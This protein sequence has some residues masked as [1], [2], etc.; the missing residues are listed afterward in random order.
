MKPILLVVESN[1]F[2][3]KAVELL[4]GE[5][6]VRLTDLQRDQLLE[7]VT[8]VDVLWVRLRNMIDAEVIDRANN[9]KMIATNTTGLNHI[10]LDVAH[11][12]NISVVS[13]KGEYDFLADIRATAEHTIGLT[14]ALLRRIP[15]AHQHVCNGHWDRYPFKGHELYQ[16]TAGIIGLGRL[17]KITARYFK[18]F[19][20]R[21]VAT[22][23]NPDQSIDEVE[24]VSLD[25]L[26]RESDVIS[27]HVDYKPAN[28]KMIDRNLLNKLRPNAVFINTSRG[29][30]VDESDLLDALKSGSIAGAALDV[31]DSEHHQ[32][33]SRDQLFQY[34]ATNDNLI[35]TPHIGG[36]TFESHHKTEEYLA[37]LVVKQS[38]LLN[39]SRFN[40]SL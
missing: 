28:R 20:M 30:L 21:I 10:D 40:E 32:T 35:M 39:S 1:D 25:E 34:A 37:G 14:L 36:N 18:A 2:S 23:P 38:R 33:S 31:I 9:L 29:E 13:L 5:F 22:D 24:F 12:R 15:A 3:P 26:A 17:G 6:E 16:R 8:G 11:Q 4:S 27:L 19:G 7:N